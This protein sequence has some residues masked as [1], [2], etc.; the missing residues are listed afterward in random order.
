VKLVKFRPGWVVILLIPG[1]YVRPAGNKILDP[2]PASHPSSVWKRLVPGSVVAVG[3]LL[4]GKNKNEEPGRILFA[5][6][7]TTQSTGWASAVP[8]S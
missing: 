8:M 2:A 4:T 3:G 6:P 1:L 5:H 7:S